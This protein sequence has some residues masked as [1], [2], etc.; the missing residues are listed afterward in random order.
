MGV[1]EIKRSAMRKL[2]ELLIGEVALTSVIPKN[3]PVIADRFRG[4]LRQ[5]YR[6]ART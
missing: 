6:V 3:M 1:S 4:A 2:L 5:F